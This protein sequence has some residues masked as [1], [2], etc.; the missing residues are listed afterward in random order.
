MR[1]EQ[2]FV[3][4]AVRVGPMVGSTGRTLLRRCLSGGLG[5]LLERFKQSG[6]GEIAEFWVKTGPNKQC[7]ETEFEG[8]YWTLY[9]SK[10][11]YRETS[12]SPGF[13]ANCPPPLISIRHKAVSQT[14]AE[15]SRA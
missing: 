6:Q 13:A 8:V 5:E 10:Q 2:K 1:M 4:K 14:D 11:V 9:R 12:L 15:F 3:A 7:N